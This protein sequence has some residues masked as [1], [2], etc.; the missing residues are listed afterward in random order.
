MLRPRFMV[1]HVWTARHLHAYIDGE[2][3]AAER[4]R[5]EDHAHRCPHCAELIATLLR[6][7]AELGELGE[8]AEPPG[9]ADGV[10]ARLRQP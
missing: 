2:L 5:I 9:L 3:G 7:I 10:I 8:G 4:A 6:V 1:D